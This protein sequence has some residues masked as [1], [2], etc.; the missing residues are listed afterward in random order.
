MAAPPAQNFGP[1]PNFNNIMQNLN[2]VMNEVTLIPNIPLVGQGNVIIQLLQQLQLE[3]Q[4]IQ[5][6]LQNVQ[7]DVQNVQQDLQNVQ[8]D[9]QNVQQDL[10]NVQQDL[11]NVQRHVQGIVREQSLLPTKLFNSG[12]REHEPLVYPPGVGVAHPPLPL[13]RRELAQMTAKVTV[14]VASKIILTDG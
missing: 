7:R 3:V 12:A 2:A 9:V 1:Q 4:N 11:Q 14:I 10:Q 5:R 8:R 13:N 6:G